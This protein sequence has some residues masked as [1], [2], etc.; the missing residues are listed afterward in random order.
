M[1]GPEPANLVPFGTT[2]IISLVLGLVLGRLIDWTYRNPPKRALT[3]A[4]NWLL[5]RF[6]ISDASSKQRLLNIITN[7]YLEATPAK[8]QMRRPIP[9]PPAMFLGDSTAPLF[10]EF[11][12]F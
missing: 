2:A 9:D 10:G 7:Y 3:A 11:D 1:I 6:T 4:D 12:R 5:D 8:I